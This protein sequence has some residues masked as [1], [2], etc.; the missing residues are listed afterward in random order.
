MLLHFAYAMLNN[1]PL[2]LAD[3]LHYRDARGLTALLNAFTARTATI[4]AVL[5]LY[6]TGH[7][8]AG[9]CPYV[10]IPYRR[11]T[12]RHFAMRNRYIVWRHSA[13]QLP[14]ETL[15]HLDETLP[16]VTIAYHRNTL[17]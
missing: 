12:V 4:R 9:A 2:H 11:I 7:Y 5:Y 16:R 15:R 10:A 1:A 14:G 3:A 17:P 13:L 8:Y 6:P